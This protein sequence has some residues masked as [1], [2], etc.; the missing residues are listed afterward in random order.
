[1]EPDE[2]IKNSLKEN[3]KISRIFKKEKYIKV[4]NPT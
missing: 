1:M 4:K 2:E 3:R